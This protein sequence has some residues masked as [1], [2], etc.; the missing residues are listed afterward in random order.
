MTYPSSVQSRPPTV[1]RGRIYTTE[2]LDREEVSHY[3]LTVLA[4]DTTDQPLS[5][6]A[7]VTITVL[8]SNDNVP[9]FVKDTF[10]FEVDE[11]TLLS[12]F[13]GAIGEISVRIII[14]I[15]LSY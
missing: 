1:T 4:Q 3:E 5:G 15:I 6:T 7:Q 12:D 13:G 9:K 2:Q 10:N 8:D 11:E 14:G